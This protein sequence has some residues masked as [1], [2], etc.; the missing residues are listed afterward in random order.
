MVNE[1]TWFA[2]GGLG[3]LLGTLALA[4]GFRLI[5]R[6]NWR[7]Y[8]L[9]VAV[10]G[11]AVGAYVPMAL[12]IG[13]IETLSG[14]S[15]FIPRYIDWLLTTPLHVLY[16]GLLAGA[17]RSSLVRANVLM[18]LTILL[19][20]GGAF[21]GGVAGWGLFV[22]G[23]AAFAGVI[24]YTYT[25]FATAAA[26]RDEVTLALYQKLRAF[27][28]VLWLLYPGIWILAPAGLGLLNTATYVLVI[29]Y[30][31]VVSKV[32][33]GLIALSGQ[34]TVDTTAAEGDAPAEATAD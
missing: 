17:S 19:G 12:G 14:G 22:L 7:R 11:I 28:I 21:V 8:S 5:P 31:D 20:F 23:S 33:F 1:T 26:E 34:V 9:L 6:S 18:A 27:V 30:L 4:V 16:L 2:L 25:D 32:G 29:S 24:Y 10:P 15:I 13:A 3:M